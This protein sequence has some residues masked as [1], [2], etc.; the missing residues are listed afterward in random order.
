VL[1]VGLPIE[2]FIADGS[3]PEDFQDSS[4]TSDLEDIYFV[5]YGNR[6]LLRFCMIQK[7]S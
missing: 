6:N 4:E 2:F 1:P 5:D 7:D 3:W